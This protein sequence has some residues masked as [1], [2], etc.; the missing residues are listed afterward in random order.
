[1]LDE[2]EWRPPNGPK[3]IA[4]L[5]AMEFSRLT[6]R[7]AEA[8]GVDVADVEPAEIK[9]EFGDAAHGPDVG[10][11]SLPLEGRVPGEA[12]RVGSD[13]TG[14]GAASA[15]SAAATP[16]DPSGHPP[17]KGEGTPAALAARRAEA[18]VAAKIDVNAYHCIRDLP[19]LQAWVAEAIEE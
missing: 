3:L 19:T 4:F 17:L 7:V 14:A 15:P 8:S 18:A 11:A 12:R 9:V 10:R 5:K 2:F 6:R 13:A 16:P 1:G